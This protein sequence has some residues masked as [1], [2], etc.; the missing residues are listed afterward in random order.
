MNGRHHL[1]WGVK[2]L[3]SSTGLMAAEEGAEEDTE[4]GQKQE[5][6]LQAAPVGEAGIVPTHLHFFLSFEDCFKIEQC[7][8]P[9]SE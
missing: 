4:Y 2:C 9:F 8:Y 5:R 1:C 7:V 3:V 6:G